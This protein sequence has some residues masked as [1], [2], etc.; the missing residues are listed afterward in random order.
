MAQWIVEI[1]IGRLITDDQFR[2]EFL[3]DPES[4]LLAPAEHSSQLS[5]TEIAALL[6]TDLTLWQEIAD[7]IDPRLQRAALKS[8]ARV[9]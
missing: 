1:V 3:R 8:E 7:A 2:E 4:T 5:S 9:S 6:N